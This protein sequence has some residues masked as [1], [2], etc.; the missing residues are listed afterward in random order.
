MIRKTLLAFAILIVSG[1]AGH[2]EKSPVDAL[3]EKWLKPNL[4]SEELQQA[5]DEFEAAAETY[6][7]TP[8]GERADNF[9]RM[10]RFRIN[11]KR[12]WAK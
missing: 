1:C 9:A 12:N 3:S 6:K 11:S 7:D 10:F 2:D 4:T 5:T 8:D